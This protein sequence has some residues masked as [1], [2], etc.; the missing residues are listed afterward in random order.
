MVNDRKDYRI[1]EMR[2]DEYPLLSDFL[3]EA[4]FQKDETN[5][6]PK[7]II[8]EPALQVYVEWEINRRCLGQE[9]LWVWE[10]G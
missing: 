10:R 9:Y 5:P 2:P 4:I 3:Y 6:A 7:T 1:R 8:N